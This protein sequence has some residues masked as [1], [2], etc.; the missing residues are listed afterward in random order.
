MAEKPPCVVL[1]HRTADQSVHYDWLIAPDA[2]ERDPE[3]RALGHLRCPE[4]PDLMSV[5]DEMGV[6][7]GEPHRWL[8]LTYEGGLSEGRGEVRRVA[9]GACAVGEAFGKMLL[10]AEWSGSGGGGAVYDAEARGEGRR[11]LR[12]IR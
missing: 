5:G 10:S 12:R 4:R 1:E 9:Q 6:E 8:Y 3:E 7:E 11:L 2:K